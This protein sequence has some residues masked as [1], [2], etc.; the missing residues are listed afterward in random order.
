MIMNF[1]ISVNYLYKFLKNIKNRYL[2]LS[3]TMLLSF[4][5][6]SCSSEQVSNNKEQYTEGRVEKIISNLTIQDKDMNIENQTAKIQ[7]MILNGADKDK[8]IV[9]NQQMIP[10]PNNI[11]IPDPGDVVILS[12]MGLNNGDI[13]LQI[14]D[15]RRSNTTWMAI[16]FF[17]I[18][19]C[20]I[21]GIKGLV[22]AGLLILMFAITVFILFPLISFG[23]SPVFLTL[24]FSF[25]VSL[26]INFFLTNTKEKLRQNVIS[27]FISLFVVTVFSY[28]FSKYGAFGSLIEKE[29]IGA[30]T[31]NISASGF[32][33]SAIILTSLGGIINVAYSTSNLSK[34]VKKTKPKAEAN[35]IFYATLK[36]S[37]PSVF[38]NFLFIFLIYLGL[39]LPVLISRYNVSPIQT[40]VNLDIIS[41]YLIATSIGG[42][43]IITSSLISCAISSY[44]PDVNSSGKMRNIRATLDVKK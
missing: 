3:I 31:Q 14:I 42:L 16:A 32:I 27:N 11:A 22:F 5:L 44:M 33:A 8:E 15:V 37:R 13:G 38:I 30:V 24:I 19:L 18:C 34:D 20:A 35:E 28:I 4:L 7:I 12:E 6:F 43:G 10:N 39:A 17:I 9:I 26:L 36:Y 29:S 1:K 41:F 21:G 23:I 2:L 25:F 40:I